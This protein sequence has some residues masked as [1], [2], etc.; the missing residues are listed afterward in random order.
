MDLASEMNPRRDLLCLPLPKC[1]SVLQRQPYILRMRPWSLFYLA[2]FSAAPPLALAGKMAEFHLYF[3]YIFHSW[4]EKKRYKKKIRQITDNFF[5]KR[6]CMFHC[7]QWFTWKKVVP[8]QEAELVVE[9]VRLSPYQLGAWLTQT[10]Q[11]SV[12]HLHQYQLVTCTVL[13]AIIIRTKYHNHSQVI[14]ENFHSW[15]SEVILKIQ[16]LF[17]IICQKWLQ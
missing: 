16:N 2:V 4:R 11:L 14:A 15:N 5:A 7:S 1:F 9:V 13:I 3:Q 6:I 12:V 17:E 10:H 8:V